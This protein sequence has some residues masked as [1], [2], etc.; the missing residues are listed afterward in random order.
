LAVLFEEVLIIKYF[1]LSSG[2]KVEECDATK[3]NQGT[4]AGNTNKLTVLRTDKSKI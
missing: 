2:Q 3:V 4:E 1:L